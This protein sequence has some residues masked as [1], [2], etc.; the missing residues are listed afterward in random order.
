MN[1]IFGASGHA[2][3]LDLFLSSLFCDK[4]LYIR[5]FVTNSVSEQ[6][7]F[8]YPTIT[9]EEFINS[10]DITSKKEYQCYI[11]IGNGKIRRNVAK[12]FVD[13]SCIKFSNFVPE[14]VVLNSRNIEYGVGN[15]LF[16]TV[17]L[18]TDITIGNHNH[19][20][21]NVSVSH[22]CKIGDYNTFSPGVRIAG[23]VSIGNDNFFGIG[24]CVIDKVIIG[25]DIIIGAGAVVTENLLLPGTYVGV[26][27]RKIK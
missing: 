15:V 26:P 12:K 27:A 1:I 19:F 10:I 9:E 18:T 25:N 23:S 4:I 5:T 17:T 11:A 13:Y 20:N 7:N 6:L 22:D 3:E 16:P 2:K 8:A 21:L 14:S 24:A